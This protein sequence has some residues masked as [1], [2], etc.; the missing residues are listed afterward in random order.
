M[1]LTGT[2]AGVGPIVSGDHVE[3]ALA[4]CSTGKIL[5]TLDFTVVDREGG[6]SYQKPS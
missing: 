6:Y 5:T 2:P 3:C 4:D 1:I